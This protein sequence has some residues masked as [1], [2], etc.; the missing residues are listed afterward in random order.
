MLFET[1]VNMQQETTIDTSLLR[2]DDAV[3]IY[4]NGELVFEQDGTGTDQSAS[5]TFV[6][7]WNKIQIVLSNTSQGASL[8]LGVKILSN[9]NCLSMDC[10]HNYDTIVDNAYV[11]YVGDS[12]IEGNVVVEGTV[13]VTSKSYLQYNEDDDSLS[14]M[15]S[16]Q[17]KE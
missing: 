11:P 1:F 12:T 8:R 4:I 5:F 3:S 17:I 10:Y 15:F 7:G 14:F 2:H 6:Q 9:V 13:G 16:N